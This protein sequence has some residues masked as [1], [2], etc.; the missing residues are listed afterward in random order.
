MD[1]VNHIVSSDP[2]ENGTTHSDFDLTSIALPQ[3][4]QDMLDVKAL[5]TKVPL[6]KFHKHEWVR[7]HA[8][9]DYRLSCFILQ[10]EGDYY[11]VDPRVA[12]HVG[13]EAVPMLLYTAVNSNGAV[14]LFPVRLPGADGTLDDFARTYHR[15]CEIATRTWVRMSWN[16]HTR[17][18]D[19]IT[20]DHITREPEFPDTPFA[21]IVKIAFEG[22]SIT[23]PDHW[24]INHLRGVIE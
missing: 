20:T 21:D 8:S 18:H 22:A 12:A 14:F 2:S 13:D 7:I 9:Q 3:N 24:I 4:Y 23:T 5:L 6:R 10:F 1:P 17:Q 11:F 15:I 19:L 16:K